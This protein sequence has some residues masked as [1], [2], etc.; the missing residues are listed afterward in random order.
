[1]PKLSVI[2]PIYNVATFVEKCLQTIKLQTF[3]DFEIILVNDGSTDGSGKLCDK[4]AKN[5]NNIRVC[6]LYLHA[7]C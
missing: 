5:Y 6:I 1:M 2:V 4:Y 7:T 3:K